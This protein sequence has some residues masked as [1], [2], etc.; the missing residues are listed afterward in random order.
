LRIRKGD[1]VHVLGCGF[2]FVVDTFTVV[3]PKSMRGPKV[4]VQLDHGG[5]VDA[6]RD[7]VTR[8]PETCRQQREQAAG[9]F[10]A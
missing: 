8:E 5:Q 7:R 10:P 6:R 3:V 4:R 2:G 9:L 1:R